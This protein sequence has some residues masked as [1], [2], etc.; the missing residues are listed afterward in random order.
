MVIKEIRLNDRVK[1]YSD[2]SK[3]EEKRHIRSDA[4]NHDKWTVFFFQEEYLSS[5]VSRAFARFV[6]ISWNN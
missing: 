2:Y 6:I 5:K 4:Q 3:E 1:N